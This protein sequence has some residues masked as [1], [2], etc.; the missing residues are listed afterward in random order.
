MKEMAAWRVKRGHFVLTISKDAMNLP[1][2]EF[3]RIID[4]AYGFLGVRPQA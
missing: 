2:T 1:T 4:S 3:P